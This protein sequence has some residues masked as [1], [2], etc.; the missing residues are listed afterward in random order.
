VTSEGKC[1]AGDWFE[2]ETERQVGPTQYYEL[3]SGRA[4]VCGSQDL[5]LHAFRFSDIL[6]AKNCSQFDFALR[7]TPLA[8]CL[9]FLKYS[10]VNPPLASFSKTKRL[11]FTAKRFDHG[12]LRLFRTAFRGV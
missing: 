9:T 12:C 2:Q 6:S 5:V 11:A 7:M 4:G 10:R 8:Q 1:S 3:A